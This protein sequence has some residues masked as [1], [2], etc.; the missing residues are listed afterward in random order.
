MTLI[1]GPAQRSV[2]PSLT[3]LTMMMTK[4]TAAAAAVSGLVP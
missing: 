4:I 2:P 3:T 1:D